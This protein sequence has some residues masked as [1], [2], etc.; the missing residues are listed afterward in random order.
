MTLDDLAELF[1]DDIECHGETWTRSILNAARDAV[2]SGRGTISALTSAGANAKNFSRV[3]QF[4]PIEVMRAAML[5]IK[6]AAGGGFDEDEVS[7]T[8]PDFRSLSL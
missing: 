8:C 4:S 2:T 7:A 5:A 1:Q 6:R 3:L